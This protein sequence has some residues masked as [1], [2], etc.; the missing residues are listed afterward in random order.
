MVRPLVDYASSELTDVG[1]TSPPAIAHLHGAVAALCRL[2]VTGDATLQRRL[3]GLFQDFFE[4][5]TRQPVRY[6]AD[7]RAM[8]AFVRAL[9][10]PDPDRPL[11]LADGG[12]AAAPLLIDEQPGDEDAAATV[13]R[14]VLAELLPRYLLRPVTVSVA[15]AGMLRGRGWRP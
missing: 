3:L 9:A 12:T 5:I 1:A 6:A 8:D 10:P 15:C 4:T 2:D 14:L 11:M 7:E 13:R